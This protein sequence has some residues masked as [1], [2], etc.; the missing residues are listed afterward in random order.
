[1]LKL[2][3]CTTLAFATCGR[4]PSV[5]AGKSCEGECKTATPPGLPLTS[6][7]E[8]AAAD[9]RV[10]SGADV[11]SLPAHVRFGPEAEIT[12][13]SPFGHFFDSHPEIARPDQTPPR[14]H[15]SHIFCAP[16]VA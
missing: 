1:M 3:L 13:R 4:I 8:Y 10:G 7:L 16:T 12:R 11:G 6:D 15:A 14:R 9:I 2:Q 5:T